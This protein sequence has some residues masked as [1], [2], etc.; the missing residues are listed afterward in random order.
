M[1]S[2][3]AAHISWV[4]WT[5]EWAQP[6]A[7]AT[8]TYPPDP[9]ITLIFSFLARCAKSLATVSLRA[10]AA[11]R[12][13]SSTAQRYMAA[14]IAGGLVQSAGGALLLVCGLW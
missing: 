2:C 1:L 8:A 14:I 7:C 10:T 9:C 12:R 6:S 3:L 5:E 11:L 13:L 4:A